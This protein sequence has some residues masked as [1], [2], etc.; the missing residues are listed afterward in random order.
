MKTQHRTRLYVEAWGDGIPVVLVHGSLA[1]GAEEW[2]AQRPLADEGFQ[3]LVV[4]R[5]AYGHSPAADGEDFLADAD[6]IA[7]LLGTGA[8]VVG[9]SYGGLGAMLAAARRPGATRSLTL[10]EPA[11]A[12]CAPDDP[13]G[14]RSSTTSAALARGSPR[15]GL[16]RPLPEGRRQRSRPVPTGAARRRTPA[17]SRLPARPAL[18][19]RRAAA[20][21]SATGGFPKLV[22]SG[23]HH[24]GFDAMC[25]D[26]SARIGAAHHVVEGAGHEIQFTGAPLNDLLTTL[27]REQPV[28]ARPSRLQP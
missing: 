24:P 1:T 18:L 20:R 28:S 23:G 19:R 21:R 2:A 26:L 9:H 8:H 3:L 10:L 17:R 13:A 11:A 14:G 15:R 7:E 4:D 27:W 5:R 25:A 22:V 12:A 16:G 6:D